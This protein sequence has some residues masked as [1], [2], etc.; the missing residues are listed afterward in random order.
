MELGK[1]TPKQ[2]DE[3]LTAAIKASLRPRSAET[4]KDKKRNQIPWQDRV[5]YRGE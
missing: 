2:R 3:Q 1:Y 4:S 5:T